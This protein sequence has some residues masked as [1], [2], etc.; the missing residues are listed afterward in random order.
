MKYKTHLQ[1]FLFTLALSGCLTSINDTGNTSTSATGFKLS[2]TSFTSNGKIPLKFACT[3]LGGDNLSPALSWSAQPATTDQF[4][5]VV[6]D[7][8]SPCGTGTQACQHWSVFAIPASVQSFVAGQDIGQIAG[9]V[10]GD[11]LTN[12]QGYF[13][14][15]PPKGHN[16]NF[17][18]YAL[19][20]T[21]PAVVAGT[22]ITRAEF[23]Q[24]YAD[25]IIDSVTLVGYFDP[26]NPVVTQ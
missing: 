23:A 18:L 12:T 25:H 3:T 1:Y 14:P 22:L 5:L 24:D 13:G 9:A 20:D 2:S 17:T 16:Y 11:N 7:E 10:E 6:D 21:M 15:C 8:D 19:K 4:A 26:S